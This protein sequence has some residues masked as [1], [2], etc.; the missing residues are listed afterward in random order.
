MI[1]FSVHMFTDS[2]ADSN[3]VSGDGRQCP[4]V[5]DAASC[6]GVD[7]DCPNSYVTDSTDWST[8][9]GFI[10]SYHD[11]HPDDMSKVWGPIIDGD[12]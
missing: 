10:Y 3:S 11:S 12:Q 9:C 7:L 2:P 1:C 8:D 6:T 4:A 5:Q